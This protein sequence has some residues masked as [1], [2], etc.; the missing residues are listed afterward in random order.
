MLFRSFE[1]I[2]SDRSRGVSTIQHLSATGML[3]E[4]VSLAHMVWASPREFGLLAQSGVHVSCN[5]S[6]NLRLR[7]GIAPAAVMKSAGINLAI[8][9]DGTTLADD[10]DM[11]AE[12]RLLLNLNR[13]PMPNLPALSSKDVF[14]MAT[15]GGAALMGNADKLG[16]LEIGKKA[17]VTIVNLA[18][19]TKHWVTND[20]DPISLLLARATSKDVKHVIVNGELRLRDGIVCGVDEDESY[21]QMASEMERAQVRS[22]EKQIASDIRPHLQKWYGGWLA[23]NTKDGSSHRPAQ[24]RT[25]NKISGVG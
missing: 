25:N 20:V 6:S 24:V 7:S 13:P 4:R 2:E 18:N 21:S 12:M 5:P 9:M 19:I 15:E 11:F 1:S 10:E 16:R 3:K 14:Q 22:I 17:D 23:D 8:G